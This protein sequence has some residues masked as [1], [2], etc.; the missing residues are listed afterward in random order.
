VPA[1]IC[2]TAKTRSFLSPSFV[3]AIYQSRHTEVIS[4]LSKLICKFS[5]K[6]ACAVQSRYNFGRGGRRGEAENAA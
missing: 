4:I 2:V 5:V 1:R 6:L 3:G